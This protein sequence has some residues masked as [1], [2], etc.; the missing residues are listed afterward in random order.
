MGLNNLSC[1]WIMAPDVPFSDLTVPG[2]KRLRGPGCGER[3]LRQLGLCSSYAQAMQMDT[4]L[5]Q[6]PMLP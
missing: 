6:T 4:K 3:M 5:V 2:A 1:G